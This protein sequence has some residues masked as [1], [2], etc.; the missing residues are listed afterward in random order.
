VRGRVRGVLGGGIGGLFILSLVLH[1]WGLG[2]LHS[3]VF[4]EIYYV[5]F[6]SNYLSG[7]P[8]FDAHPPLGKYL[9]AAGIA[10]GE[11]PAAWLKWPNLQLGNQLIS[12]LSYRWLNALVGST[13]PCVVA[14]LGFYLS[15]GYEI[16][17][18]LIFALIAGTLVLLSGL[19]LVE[20]RFALINIYWVW[21][22]LLGQLCWAIAEVN[23][24]PPQTS[25]RGLPFRGLNYWRMGAGVLLGAA[26]NVK[27]NGAGFWLG[28]VLVELLKKG[29]LIPAQSK[30]TRSWSL[31]LLYL[32]LMPLVTYS[33]LWIPHL[34]LNQVSLL[35]IHRQLWAV[36]QG[37]AA[38]T[39]PHPYC[40]AWYTWPLM[41]R[42]VS[43]FYE[44]ITANYGAS[45]LPPLREPGPTTHTVQGMGNPL[46][47]WLST[48]A[49]IALGAG[50]IEQQIEH[51]RAQRIGRSRYPSIKRW[52]DS[53]RRPLDDTLQVGMSPVVSFVVVNYIAN[54]LPWM[55]VS[56]CTFLYHALG[57]I[58]FADL[59][60]A[61]LLSRWLGDRRWHHRLIAGAI[62]VIVL[63]GFWFWLP[64]FIGLPLSPDDLERR[65]WLRSWI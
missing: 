14:L 27:W 38:T 29:Q 30:Q 16:R 35:D 52:Q 17:R 59:A 18:R 45:I 39:A 12:P 43:Y 6:A 21:F 40:S 4:D 23:Q 55:V 11:W 36:H 32:G 54:W 28:L 31:Y 9:I 61:W 2:G 1:F 64:V 3:L 5:P 47:W 37:I 15:A 24:T 50:W 49:V 25:D 20:S 51:Y 63:W 19:P 60:L 33:L 7:E 62:L 65:W 48:A 58:M 13:L 10:L 44:F 42:P 22:G 53:F 46:L 41:L 8:F 34:R 56:R 26:M 57:M